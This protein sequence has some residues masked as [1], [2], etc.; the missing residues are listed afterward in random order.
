MNSP[1][2]IQLLG[3]LSARRGEQEI[4][5]FQTRKTGALLAYLAY[6]AKQHHCREALIE[7]LW[8]EADMHNGRHSLS[9]ALSSL[10]RQLEPPG[11]PA[12][13]VIQ[14]TNATVRLNPVAV[15]TDV[16]EFASQVQAA[17]QASERG[18]RVSLLRRAIEHYPGD[19][20]PGFFEDWV[21][22]E[23]ERLTQALFHVLRQVVQ[24]LQKMGESGLA[25]E[26]A[27]RALSVAPDMEATHYDVMHSYAAL[28]RHADAL[29]LYDKLARMLQR[30]GG[31]RPSVESRALAKQC[32]AMVEITIPAVSGIRSV[33]PRPAPPEG[34]FPS[35]RAVTPSPPPASI[36]PAASRLPLKLTQFF[37]RET[38]IA[39]LSALLQPCD[40]MPVQSLDSP[41]EPEIAPA[42]LVTLVG[43]GGAGKTRLAVELARQ[44]AGIYEE[45]VY[46]VPLADVTDPARIPDAVLNALELPHS[47]NAPPLEQVV[48][49][50]AARPALLLLDNFEQIDSDGPDIV[51][52]LLERLPA[53][54][55]LVTSRQPLALDGEVE[56][57][58]HPLPV[59]TRP[60]TPERLMEFACV[61]MFADRAR[62]VCPD[63][64]VTPRNAEAIVAVCRQ[65]EGIPLA[66]ELAAAR[67]M[68]LTPAQMLTQLSE[69]FDF[70]VSKRGHVEGRH[71][72]L[73]EAIDWSYEL[74]TPE[75][76]RFFARLSVFR[77]GW[78]LEAAQAVCAE[79]CAL[80]FSEQL[81]QRSLVTAEEQGEAMR[82]RM[83]ETLRE[84]AG[85][86][87]G[88]E[89]RA[90]A[91]RRHADF[92]LHLAEEAQPHL[93]GS[94]R[95]QWLDRLDV[96]HDNFRAALAASEGS[97]RSLRLAGALWPF[98]LLRGYVGEGRSCLTSALQPKI[99]APPEI[100]AKALNGLG[101]LAR[102]QGGFEEAL[103]SL[104]ESLALYRLCDDLGGVS[105]S[106]NGLAVLADSQGDY[107]RARAYNEE[108][109]QLLRAIGDKWGIAASLNNLGRRALEL[110][111]L[112][113]A[114]SCYR[115]SQQIY[116]ELGDWANAAAV[117]SNLGT[118]AFEQGN[119]VEARASF[120]QSLTLF[121][122]M[123]NQ[124][125][126]AVLLHNLGETLCRQ[127]EYAAAYP[128]LKESLLLRQELGDRPGAA[129][130]L[131][132]LGNVA[133]N[134]GDNI[135][136]TR[137]LAAAEAIHKAFDAPLSQAG[138]MLYEQ[139]VAALRRELSANDFTA[140]WTYG[141]T[142]TLERAIAYALEQPVDHASTAPALIDLAF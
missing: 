47:A 135:R 105:Q 141:R 67:C 23:R 111:D 35:Q 49:A 42:R 20:L 131:A 6:H 113:V 73:R 106:L 55:C 50:L 76:Q 34:A 13:S 119:F 45:A 12:G 84:Y 86:Q 137:L 126:V 54:T 74:L 70:L 8:P 11:V 36:R 28:G 9:Q 92:F 32:R 31:R 139:D 98:W 80:D 62:M 85:E 60:G 132:S 41:Q 27:L 58:V 24:D 71:R 100:R 120:E 128:L 103:S 88:A 79:S 19:L 51:W 87:L 81:L 69:R 38:E 96:E 97:E 94:E 117:L 21:L 112:P 63:F 101:V 99:E 104:E 10:R 123:R 14:T 48:E 17:R 22:V 89:E 102:Q 4:L 118:A 26:Y 72:T 52:T 7:N 122:E 64:Q 65:L 140:A 107:A 44:L 77:G 18:E 108:S 46:F 134:E 114:C 116:Q 40:G 43:P 2:R 90:E 124:S 142:M 66:I 83:L 57:P 75:L 133:R 39:R 5:R 95:Q 56:Y 1:W 59:P 68:A 125:F 78:T 91:A 127:E 33:E 110:G 82:F 25:L 136:A 37:G 138:H 115:E 53:V 16:S 109:L 61:Q 93:R 3:G 121:R 29:R 30:E 130:S 15:T 129:F